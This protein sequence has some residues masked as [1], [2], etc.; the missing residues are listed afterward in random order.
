ME[1]HRRVGSIA[2]HLLLSPAADAT[3]TAAAATG[4]FKMV[5]LTAGGLIEDTV[6]EL[7]TLHPH[8]TFVT[9][10]PIE[11]GG[12]VGGG[13][14]AGLFAELADATAAYGFLTPQMIAAA[15]QMRWLQLPAAA[16]PPEV[17]TRELAQSEIT[18]TNMRGIY[19]DELAL[20]ILTLMLSVTRQVGRYRDQQ[21]EHRWLKLGTSNPG[22]IGG[23]TV[24]LPG[25][26]ALMV[27]VGNAGL[28]TARLLGAIGMRVLGVDARRTGQCAHVDELHP[29]S[30]LEA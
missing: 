13:G 10:P 2:R 19:D 21:R 3:T 23:S 7:Q 26:T 4:C 25:S 22:G 5:F 14:Q 1:W 17:F 28:E 30:A 12:A 18:V 15:P 20:H 27:G 8:A 9:A 16:P 6:R 24:D 29:P 11:D